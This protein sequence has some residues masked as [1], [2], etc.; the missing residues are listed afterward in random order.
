MNSEEFQGKTLEERRNERRD[1]VIAVYSKIY[2]LAKI[3]FQILTA[4]GIE[5]GKIYH[6]QASQ[7]TLVS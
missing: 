4:Y 2:G 1:K 3:V 6:K 5:V 7:Q